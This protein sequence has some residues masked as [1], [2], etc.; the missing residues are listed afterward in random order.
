MATSHTHMDPQ[1]KA[2]TLN[3]RIWSSH[4]CIL[5]ESTDFHGNICLQFGAFSQMDLSSP[6]TVLC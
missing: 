6:D 4:E 1:N 2:M 3:T 5:L